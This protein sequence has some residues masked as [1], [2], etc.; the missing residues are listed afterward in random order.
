MAEVDLDRTGQ[1][2]YVLDP[3]DDDVLSRLNSIREKPGRQL[4]PPVQS[5]YDPEPW[6]LLQA[7]SQ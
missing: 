2:L 6:K 4:G 7:E 3:I 1:P 5:K